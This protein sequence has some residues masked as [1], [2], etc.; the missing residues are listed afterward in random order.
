MRIVA[1]TIGPMPRPIKDAAG[2]FD[3]MPNITATFENGQVKELF[4]FYPDE[5]SFTTSEFIGLTEQEAR[6]LR[7]KKDVVYLRS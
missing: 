4:S 7:L 5:L 6:A 3:S 2:I 1:A